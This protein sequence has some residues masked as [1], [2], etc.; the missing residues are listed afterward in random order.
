MLIIINSTMPIS[1][2]SHQYSHSYSESHISIH[3]LP[4]TVSLKRIAQ[5]F[6]QH[7]LTC[8]ILSQTNNLCKLFQSEFDVFNALDLMENSQFLDELKFGQGDGNLQ[9]Y[10]YNW[11][12]P[13]MT[14]QKVGLYPLLIS[15][16]AAYFHQLVALL[17]YK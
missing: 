17:V 9:Y 7:V 15:N 10:L 8:F 14:P 4:V 1:P 6:L 5:Y 16:T 12:C 2:A 3:K 11:R 13:N